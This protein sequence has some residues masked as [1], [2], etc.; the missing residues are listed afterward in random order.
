MSAWQPIKSAPTD[1]TPFLMSN[2][3]TVEVGWWSAADERFPW[4]FVDDTAEA[5]TGCCDREETERVA[6]N[7][8]RAGTVLWWQPLPEPPAAT[9]Q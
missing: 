5:I 3:R 7:A 8:Y 1:G 4:R 2:G 9:G 6:T